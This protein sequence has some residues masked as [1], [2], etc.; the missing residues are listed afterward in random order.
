MPIE[1]ID[2]LS[3]NNSSQ[4]KMAII[5]HPY[6]TNDF[7]VSL[8]IVE[9]MIKHGF[10]I[11]TMEMIT[12]AEKVAAAEILTL[13]IHNHWYLT[14]EERLALAAVAQ[15]KSVKGIIYLTPLTADRIF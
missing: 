4:D 12:E 15:D 9:K 8:N 6:L 11:R 7:Q 1:I 2:S 13:Q 14:N 3:I 10:G 5:G